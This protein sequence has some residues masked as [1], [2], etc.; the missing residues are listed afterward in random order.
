L[1][2]LLAVDDEK[3][4]CEFLEVFFKEKGYTIFTAS[5]PMDAVLITKK[6]HPDIV[7]L[8]IHMPQNEGLGVL[9]EIKSFDKNIKVIM[10]TVAGDDNTRNIA[11]S[12]GADSYV[13]KPFELSKLEELALKFIHQILKNKGKTA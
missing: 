6:E 7:F 4:I 2:K 11:L 1:I 5:T 12:L 3:G 9:Q 13:I 10:I 8:D